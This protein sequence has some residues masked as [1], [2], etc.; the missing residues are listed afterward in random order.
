MRVADQ[1]ELPAAHWAELSSDGRNVLYTGA[2]GL[3][4]RRAD[5]TREQ[6]VDRP[7]PAG[8]LDPDHAAWS[9]DG[10]KLAITEAYTLGL[11]PDIHVVDVE[12]GQLTTLT[13]DGI[14]QQGTIGAGEVVLPDAALVDLYPSWS[15][16]SKQIRFLRKAATG[17]AVM[18]VPATGGEPTSLGTLDTEWNALME[19]AWA[20][21]AI[22]WTTGSRAEGD[23]EVWVS[24]LAGGG[25]HKVLDGQYRTLSFS[26]DGAFLLA[27]Q[28]DRDGDAAVGK[29]RVVPARGGDPVPVAAG[30][31]RY[32]TWAPEGHAIAYVDAAE[33]VRVV[34]EPG[35]APRDLHREKELGAADHEHLGWAPGVMLVR[36]GED[37]PVVLRITG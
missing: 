32:P 6:C 24:T 29:A 5:G 27:D 19:V 25:P 9:P 7:D 23:G 26:A 17:V 35:A 36:V 14:T 16:D 30:K 18:A 21:N 37:T 8:F 4:V 28:Q 31:V 22:A 1:Q 34:G 12:T 13:D 11:E 3:C 2:N 20:E 15:A 10:R 33:T